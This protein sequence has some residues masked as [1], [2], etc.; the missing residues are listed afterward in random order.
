MLS[1]LLVRLEVFLRPG[2]AAGFLTHRGHQFLKVDQVEHLL[3]VV[4]QRR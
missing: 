2:A 1:Q 4:C 3:E